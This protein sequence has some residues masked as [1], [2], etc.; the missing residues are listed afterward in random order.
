MP[1]YDFS[2]S[3][4]SH[5]FEK[6]LSVENRKRPESEPCPNCN[7]ERT[8]EFRIGSPAIVDPYRIGR[9]KTSG[10]FR[11]KMEMIARNNP[12]HKMNLR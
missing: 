12:G 4:C 2:C 3:A 1:N 5:S 11:E 6:I 10:A 7:S 9:K 8:V